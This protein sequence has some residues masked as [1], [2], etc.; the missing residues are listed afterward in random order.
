MSDR[1]D[2]RASTPPNTSDMFKKAMDYLPD[3]VLVVS[4]TRT[5]CYANP[6]FSRCDG[7]L[8]RSVTYEIASRS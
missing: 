7:F 2:L 4:F 5:I 8:L 3:G 1:T 6:A